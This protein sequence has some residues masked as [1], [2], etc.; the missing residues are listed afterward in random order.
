MSHSY[1]DRLYPGRR[2]GTGHEVFKAALDVAE[3]GGAS[4]A[5][6]YL[7]NRY[8]ERASVMGVPLDL[9]AGAGLTAAA[10][11]CDLKGWCS[12]LVP[13]VRNVGHAGVGAYF[14]TMGAGH[15]AKASGVKRLLVHEKDVGK[16]KA[17]LPDATVLGAIPRAPHG[18]FLSASELAALAR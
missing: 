17:V 3:Y 10:L 1:L 11:L 8:R 14:H 4:Y 7:Q 9:A 16:V 12:G 13:I 6:G 18:D 15:G 5:F 2:H